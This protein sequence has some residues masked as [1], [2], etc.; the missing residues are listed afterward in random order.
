[1]HTINGDGHRIEVI[2]VTHRSNGMREVTFMD[3]SNNKVWSEVVV[4][5]LVT[6]CPERSLPA[7]LAPL[8]HRKPSIPVGFPVAEQQTP[9]CPRI[10]IQVDAPSFVQAD[11][12]FSR[13]Y[14]LKNARSTEEKDTVIQ[15]AY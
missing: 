5:S 7:P 11:Q 15:V 8:H 4:L 2:D 1:M 13:V 6:G 10:K 12:H 3:R 9:S 14:K